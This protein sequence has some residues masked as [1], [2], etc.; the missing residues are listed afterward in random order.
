MQIVNLSPAAILHIAEA[1]SRADAEGKRFR[2][3]FNRGYGDVQPASV[4]FKVGEGM[5]SAPFYDEPDPYRDLGAAQ[6]ESH[7]LS[8]FGG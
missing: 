4:S 6:H 3:A 5:W 2:L 8:R 7:D 1:A